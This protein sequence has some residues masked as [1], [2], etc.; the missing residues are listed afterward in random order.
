MC[1]SAMIVYIHLVQKDPNE[2]QTN[3]NSINNEGHE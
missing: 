1:L 2:T 3:S